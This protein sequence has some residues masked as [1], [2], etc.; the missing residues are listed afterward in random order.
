MN[1]ILEE[2]TE[3]KKEK[4]KI[5]QVKSYDVYHKQRRFRNKLKAS[6]L[7]EYNPLEI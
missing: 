5:S 3:E 4:R 6:F 7:F 1:T 2:E